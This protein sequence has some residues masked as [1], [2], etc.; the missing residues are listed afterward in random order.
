MRFGCCGNLGATGP[1]KTAIEI[2]E[3]LASMGYDYIELPLA[4]MMDLPDED[5]SKLK[6]R[7]ADSGIFCEVCNNLFPAKIR[8]TGPDAD[9]KVISDYID[10]AFNRAAQL[11]VSTVVF[12]SGGAKNV[13]EGFPHEK[14]YRQVADITQMLAPVAQK[15][16]IT[17]VIEPIRKPECNII[18]SFKE[19]VELAQ[20]IQ[21]PN[22]RVLID[23]YHM[24]WENE[25]PAI[26]RLYGREYLRHVHFANPNLR[27]EEGR[28]KGRIYPASMEEWNYQ[29]FIDIL[30]ETGYDGRISIEAGADNF[31]SQAEAALKFLHSAF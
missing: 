12:G 25:S 9:M 23:Y 2:L 17:V 4:E 31:N 14:A 15:Y 19:G 1:D 16:D 18:N 8:L 7:V 22:I 3:K 29:E 10:R 27:T 24:V 28:S 13:P 11:G 5:F 21:H 26:L 20:E 30:K 6:K